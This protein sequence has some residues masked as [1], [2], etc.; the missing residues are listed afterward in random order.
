MMTANRV[1]ARHRSAVVLLALVMT[2]LGVVGPARRAETAPTAGGPKPTVVLVHGAF[3]DASG[4]NGVAAR[5]QHDGYRVVA[6]ANPLRDLAGD[7]HYLASILATIPAPVVLVGHSYGGAVITNAAVDQPNVRALVYI[8]AFAPDQGESI[9]ELTGRY[10]GSHL[11]AATRLR[12]FPVPGGGAGADAYIDPA[13]FR[14][15]FVGDAAADTAAV[16]AAA[17]RPLSVDAGN[18]KTAAVA[19]KSIPSW[20]LVATEDHAIPPDA[21]RFMAGRA[22][23][24]TI[25]I[26]GPHAVM[27]T[28][29]Q[30]VTDLIERAATAVA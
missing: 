27:V 3:A 5:L 15:V 10:P 24:E 4:W 11:P 13:D 9:F 21:E 7:A 8:A 23:S 17:Q 25:E 18:G 20:Y 16:M 2:G 22:R 1:S 14:D 30:H 26:D 29:P 6:P 12:P 19:W 28:H